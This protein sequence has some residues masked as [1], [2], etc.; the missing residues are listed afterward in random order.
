M[1]LCATRVKARQGIV[2]S[3]VDRWLS[4]LPDVAAGNQTHVLR[5]RRKQLTTEP[6]SPQPWVL[7]VHVPCGRQAED[8]L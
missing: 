3:E 2:S 5:K 1:R 6:S 4:E 7:C 8:H